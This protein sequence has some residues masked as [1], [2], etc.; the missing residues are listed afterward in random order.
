M[1]A[2]YRRIDWTG[3]AP[4][5]IR[6]GLWCQA[7]ASEGL[8]RLLGA[9]VELSDAPDVAA[10]LTMRARVCLHRVVSASAAPADEFLRVS[11]ECRAEFEEIGRALARG[12]AA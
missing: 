2:T 4:W 5:R 3:V 6:L 12:D 10:D 11:E 7:F 9:T 8:A 1:M